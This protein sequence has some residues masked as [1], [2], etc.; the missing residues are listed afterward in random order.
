MDTAARFTSRYDPAE[1]RIQ[2]LLE[3]PEEG[4]LTLWLTRRL[5][6]RLLPPLLARLEGTG[7]AAGRGAGQGGQAP[8]GPPA[9]VQRFQQEAA[10][11]AITRQPAVSPDPG[12]RPD[13][14]IA[15]LVTSVDIRSGASAVILDFKCG[16]NLLHSLPFG[17]DTLR[18]WLGIIHSQYRA[19]KWAEPFWPD[20]IDTQKQ[21]NAS[22]DDL[23]LN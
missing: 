23:L 13:E 18:Q 15:Y 16:E 22:R 20:W 6:S 1:D 8:Q 2:I 14:R 5:L 4:V 19:A 9:A 10:V 12:A 17:G 7:P 3:R 11:S 21:G